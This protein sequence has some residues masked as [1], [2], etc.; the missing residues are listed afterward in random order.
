MM[1]RPAVVDGKLSVDMELLAQSV[2]NLP[3]GSSWIGS[4]SDYEMGVFLARV[5]ELRADMG[6]V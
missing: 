1:R 6:T 4:L 5:A 2:A 3:P